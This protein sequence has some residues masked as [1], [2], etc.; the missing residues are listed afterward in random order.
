[1]TR[2][3]Y[4]IL[5]FVA[6]CVLAA[7][8]SPRSRRRP[9]SPSN[10]RVDAASTNPCVVSHVRVEGSSAARIERQLQQYGLESMR[11]A[12]IDAFRA[13]NAPIHRAVEF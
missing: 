7:D 13:Q 12:V 2:H 6:S 11:A 10:R 3:V 5:L 9:L 8:L 1:V 4:V